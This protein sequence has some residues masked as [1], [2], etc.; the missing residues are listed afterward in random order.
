MKCKGL[1]QFSAEVSAEACFVTDFMVSF[2]EGADKK[3]YSFV[4]A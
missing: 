1:L 2:G 3:V 4:L